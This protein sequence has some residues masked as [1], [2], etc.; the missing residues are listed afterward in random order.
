[1]R[2][3]KSHRNNRRSH[4]ALKV[5]PYSACA[6]C[7]GSKIPHAVC[8]NCGWYQ[9]RQVVDVLRKLDKK[10]R[11]QKEKELAGAEASSAKPLD[12]AELSKG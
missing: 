2:H 12:A 4:H 5:A 7:G 11:K 6:H 8:A 1:M 10:A 9:G 3:T